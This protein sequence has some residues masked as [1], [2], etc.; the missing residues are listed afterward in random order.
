MFKEKKE[1]FNEIYHSLYRLIFTYCYERTNKNRADAEDIAQNVFLTLWLNFDV[2]NSNANID[3]RSWLLKTAKLKLYEY[4]RN[5]KKTEKI[6]YDLESP[7]YTDILSSEP[8]M[9]E[10]IQRL[11]V[12]HN[13][14]KYKNEILSRLNDNER[15]LYKMF[16]IDNMKYH[17]AAKQSGKSEAAFRM[18]V[19][20]LNRRIEMIVKEFCSTL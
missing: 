3:Y 10:E 11:A 15:E 19:S 6:S 5:K 7:E 2:L 18:K 14:E 17:E 13:L 16:Y 4:Y 12:D 9:I 1:K 20:R 8:D